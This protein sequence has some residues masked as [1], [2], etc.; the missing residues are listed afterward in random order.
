MFQDALHQ[1]GIP[2]RA[3]GIMGLSRAMFLLRFGSRE[4]RNAALA[5]R[6]LRSAGTD[7]RLMEWSDRVGGDIG[8]LS[9]RV[10]V[11]LEGVPVHARHPEAVASLFPGPTFIDEVD[12]RV[13]K[14]EEKFC[15]NL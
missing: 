13:Y 7:F 2:E 15:F 10:R 8:R 1:L 11:C 14:E 9:F 4:L 12:N 5:R 6:R 3:L